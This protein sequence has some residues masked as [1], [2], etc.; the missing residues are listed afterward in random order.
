MT[1]KTMVE[2]DANLMVNPE[3]FGEAA[4]YADAQ[5]SGL[6]L[7][8]DALFAQVK[9]N[10][11]EGVIRA[12]RVTVHAPAT[13]FTFGPVGNGVITR[14]ST[15]AQYQIDHDKIALVDGIYALGC[16]RLTRPTPRGGR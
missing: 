6:T 5:H 2:N 10:L 12:E 15:G 7:S 8:F 9:E 3:D 16:Q 11:A 14:T 4:T 1:F 13:A